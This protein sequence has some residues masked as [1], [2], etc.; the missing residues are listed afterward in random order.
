MP[1]VAGYS[2]VIFSIVSVRFTLKHGFIGIIAC[3]AIDALHM[4]RVNA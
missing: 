3:L 4:L 1:I 2:L